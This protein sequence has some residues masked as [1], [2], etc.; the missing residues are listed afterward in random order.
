[1]TSFTHNTLAKRFAVFCP[2]SIP[3]S[4]PGSDDSIA[5]QHARVR[6]VVVTPPELNLLLVF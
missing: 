4:V 6:I 2:L 1:M 5:S 3:A